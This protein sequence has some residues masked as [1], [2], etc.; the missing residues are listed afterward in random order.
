MSDLLYLPTRKAVVLNSWG[1]L[2]HVLD[3]KN[4]ESESTWDAGISPYSSATATKDE[5][6]FSIRAIWTNQ[7]EGLSLV[8]IDAKTGYER[9]IFFKAHGKIHANRMQT[10]SS[11]ILDEKLEVLYFIT[12]V[13]RTGTLHAFSV[14]LGKILWEK[15]FARFLTATPSLLADGCIVI[16][17]M[18]GTVHI[19]SSGGETRSRYHSG[20]YYLTSG[21]VCY[22]RERIAIG[23]P[24]GKIHII[25]PDGTGSIIFE[26]ER[27]IHARPSIDPE[28]RLFVPS[29][30]GNVY[31]FPT[32]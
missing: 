31:V 10:A 22:G 25:E 23:D 18:N 19:L 12:N 11:P 9:E 15:R 4:G 5:T 7:K 13:D 30:D 26:A 14:G 29:M 21:P 8:K 16:A 1:G 27:S 24:E 28:G 32:A 2:F 3:R 20:A 6:L 17:D